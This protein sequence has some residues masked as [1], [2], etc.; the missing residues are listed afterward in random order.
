[1]YEVIDISAQEIK[2]LLNTAEDHFNDFK[3]KQIAPNK[4]QETFVAFANADGGNIYIGI[5]DAASG[6][7]RISGFNEPEEANAIISTLL[8]NTNP[9]VE[10]VE[11]EYLRTPSNGL[12]LHVDIPKSPKVHYT[13]S[14]DCFIR[15]NAQKLK[16]KGERITQLSYSK[17]AEPYEKKAVDIVEVEDILESEYYSD[18]LRRIG[19][20]QSPRVFLKKQR[21]LTKK[22]GEF[23]PNVGCVLLFDEEPQGCLDTRCAVKVYRLR[24]TEAEYKREQLQE[25]PVT[26]EGPLEE[27]I[28]NTIAKVKEY[29]DGASFKDGENLVKLSYPAEAL[30]EILVNAV[31]HRDY[32]QKDDVHVKVYDNRIEVQSPGRLPGYMTINNLYEERFSRN[33][34]LVRLLHKLP[35]PVNHDIGE[36]LDTAKNE[37]RKAGLVAPVFEERGNN[38]VVIVKHQTIASIEDVIIN[39]FK[40]NPTG[41]LTNKLVRQLSGEDDLQK[42]KKALQKLREE[43]VIKPLDPNANPFK[44]KYIKA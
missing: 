37:L 5:E 38:F 44:F 31:I 7:E 18:Y 29:V 39:Y 1:M 35:N 20:T 9:A 10:N 15:A 19:T 23:V 8:E 13:A 32:S 11:V 21:L 22:D 17:G 28:L 2:A 26:I 25:D 36:G 34:N 14:G 27:V 43:G 33:P 30:K 40:E 6:R 24:T 4:L 12:I 41:Q 42:V 16:I 3:S